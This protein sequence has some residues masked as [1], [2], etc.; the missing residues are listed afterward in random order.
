[1]SQVVKQILHHKASKN[2]ISRSENHFGGSSVSC[3]HPQLFATNVL[4]IR[5]FMFFARC[6]MVIWKLLTSCHKQ[7]NMSWSLTTKVK[8]VI[9]TQL[10]VSIF[11]DLATEAT[12]VNSNSGWH[13]RWL[14]ISQ[15][16]TCS[17]HNSSI[18]SL[19]KCDRLIWLNENLQIWKSL[20]KKTDFFWNTNLSFSRFQTKASLLANLRNSLS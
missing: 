3:W 6:L 2:K 19:F 13:S 4:V 18:F 10:L 17:G 16:W 11:N 7:L 5:I 9:N 14:N 20:F 15:N 12:L 8:K 1:M